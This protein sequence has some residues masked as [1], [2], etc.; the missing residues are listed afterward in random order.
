M[1]TTPHWGLSL[2]DSP[3]QKTENIVNIDG[4]EASA[5]I[6]NSR[7]VWSVIGITC[8]ISRGAYSA[9]SRWRADVG[10]ECGIME[11]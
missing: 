7:S 8:N 1:S 5:L 2:A 6:H 4:A 9:H 10:E 3:K 11:A